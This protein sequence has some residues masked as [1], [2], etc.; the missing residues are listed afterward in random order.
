MGRCASKLE[1]A[2]PIHENNLTLSQLLL[3]DYPSID[4]DGFWPKLSA[5]KRLTEPNGFIALYNIESGMGVEKPALR[6]KI[7]GLF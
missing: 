2:D 3:L 6:N 1:S 7:Q 5:W 4:R